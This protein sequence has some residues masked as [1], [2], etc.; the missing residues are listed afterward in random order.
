[1]EDTIW[2]TQ[3]KCF[4]AALRCVLILIIMEDTIWEGYVAK[5]DGTFEKVLILI[6]MED[7]IWGI[8][9]AFGQKEF[10]MS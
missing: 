1:M 5:E 4:A 9:H 10:G 8:D 7:T 2:A 6:I 3:E